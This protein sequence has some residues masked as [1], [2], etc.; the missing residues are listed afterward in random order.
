MTVMGSAPLLPVRPRQQLA[1]LRTSSPRQRR[2]MISGWAGYWVDM[3]DVYLPLVALAPAIAYFQPS[4]MSADLASVLFIGTFAATMLGRPLGAILFGHWADRVGR[5]RLTLLSIAGFSSCTL[6]IGLL[7]GYAA[8]GVTAPV[9]LLALRFIN[10]VSLAA[11]TQ[12]A[13]RSRSSTARRVRGGCSV[14]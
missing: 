7:P 4:S 5:R 10:G 14:G 9:L 13:R 6:A 2:A 12:L 8:W 1:A 11:S 3:V